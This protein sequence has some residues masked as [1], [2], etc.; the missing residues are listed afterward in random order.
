MKT[1]GVITVSGEISDVYINA[2]LQNDYQVIPMMANMGDKEMPKTDAVI[3]YDGNQGETAEICK[4][5]LKIKEKSNSFIWTMSKNIS[6]VNR[7]LYLQLG[8]NGNISDPCNPYELQLIIQ[9]TFINNYSAQEQEANGQSSTKIH[10]IGRNQS[11]LLEDG[12]EIG[13]TRKEYKLI[14]TL[15]DQIGK[16]F[17]YEE[18]STIIWDETPK[19][20]KTRIANLIFH[21][22]TKLES[23]STNPQL[24]RTVRSRGYMLVI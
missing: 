23:N 12:T 20:C 5:I 19:H 24:I 4:L 3:I 16:V 11:V 22:R 17:D 13:L 9:N 18:L 2:L 8:V 7:I 6:D 10:L 15:Y 14:T 1:I 21:L